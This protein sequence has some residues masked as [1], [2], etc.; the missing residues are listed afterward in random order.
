MK[1]K[2]VKLMKTSNGMKVDRVKEFMEHLK[3]DMPNIE[4]RYRWCREEEIKMDIMKVHFLYPYPKHYY[5]QAK[6]CYSYGLYLASIQAI[7]TSIDSICTQIC[8]IRFKNWIPKWP[9]KIKAR[10]VIKDM[11][12]K[13]IISSELAERLDRFLERIRNPSTHPRPL[14]PL[15]LGIQRTD[16]STWYSEDGNWKLTPEEGAQEGILCMHLL[17]LELHY[18]LQANPKIKRKK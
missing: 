13:G 18:W 15:N 9:K 3:V 8:H 7:G 12:S 16:Y 10:K 14:G 11:K 2:D 17:I 4:Q 5:Y 1:L 6:A